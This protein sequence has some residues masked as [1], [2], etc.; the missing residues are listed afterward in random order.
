MKRSDI[1]EKRKNLN[2]NDKTGLE[3]SK[4]VLIFGSIAVV[5]IVVLVLITALGQNRNSNNY[6]AKVGNEKISVMEFNSY[7]SQVKNAM[8]NEAQI[9][10]NTPEAENFWK[11]ANFNGLSATEEAKRQALDALREMKIQV[12]K[13]K[14]KN[15]KLSSDEKEYINSQINQIIEQS[16]GK[17]KA[18][19]SLMESTGLD[20]DALKKMYTE[21][22]LAYKLYLDETSA[23]NV[24]DDEIKSEYDSDPR[25][26]D[27]V[28]VRHI[29]ISK[30]DPETGQ[31]LSEEKKIEAENKSKD[32]LNRINAGEDMEKLAKEYSDDPPVEENGGVYTFTKY[33]S[34]VDEFKEW[35][36]KANVGDTGIVETVYGYH[37]MRLE[38]REPV[39]FEDVKENIKNE[40][41]QER[42]AELLEEWKKDPAY[43][44]QT[45]DKVY[46]ELQ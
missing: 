19:E 2:K 42:F 34:Y 6:V 33:D 41:L 40:I 36:I 15:I 7:L 43:A 31:W 14:E 37:V 32:I 1:N 13:A 26:F 9:N 23:M 44:V 12:I 10:P 17:L 18:N 22:F 4:Y 29:L 21:Q 16:G 8:L 30:R 20:L 25:S 45:N 39:S 27:K 11:T 5:L 38:N 28:T 3:S 46:N 24:S 35:A